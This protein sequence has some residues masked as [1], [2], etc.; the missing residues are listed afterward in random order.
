MLNERRK[1]RYAKRIRWDLPSYEVCKD[2]AATVRE[3][4]HLA[5]R[6]NRSSDKAEHMRSVDKHHARLRGLSK[7]IFLLGSVEVQKSAQIIEHHAY[8]VREVGE[9]RE[10]R[11]LATFQNVEAEDRLE[12]EMN[13]FYR[14]VRRQLGVRDPDDLTVRAALQ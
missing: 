12:L 1:E 6:Y 14:A 13:E 10:D 8:W 9:G 11:R 2:Y 5:K 4:V 3:F 7:Q